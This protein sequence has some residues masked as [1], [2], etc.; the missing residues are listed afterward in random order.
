MNGKLG[1]SFE[2]NY[3]IGQDVL[4][5]WQKKFPQLCIALNKMTCLRESMRLHSVPEWSLEDL[6]IK[7][8]VRHMKFDRVIL[9][10]FFKN[11]LKKPTTEQKFLK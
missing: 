11:F 5:V 3:V 7:Y 2:P 1:Q 6:R 4:F 8:R 9:L 10:Y